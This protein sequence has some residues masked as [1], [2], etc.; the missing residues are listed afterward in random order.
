MRSFGILPETHFGKVVQVQNGEL[1]SMG[2][3]PNPDTKYLWD[4]YRSLILF[5]FKHFSS[6]IQLNSIAFKV[7]AS[8]NILECR[9]FTLF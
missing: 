9:D 1:E 5:V 2:Y 8:S 3:K 7:S 6:V 4:L